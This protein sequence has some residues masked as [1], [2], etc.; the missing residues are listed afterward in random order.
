MNYKIYTTNKHYVVEDLITTNQSN[1]LRIDRETSSIEEIQIN[2]YPYQ[3][4]SFCGIFG[5]I[6]LFLRK[7]LI[8]VTSIRQLGKVLGSETFQIKE[9]K[10]L[11]LSKIN[12]ETNL[13]EESNIQTLEEK[14]IRELKRLIES[15]D[16][17]FSYDSDLTFSRERYSQ[18]RK[19]SNS[20]PNVHPLN[21]CQRFF[22]NHSLCLE[23]YQFR[24][25]WVLITIRG[26]LKSCG[27]A[28][29][30]KSF[31]LILISRRLN[32]RSGQRFTR[33]GIDFEGNCANYVET[34]Q[35]IE[36]YPNQTDN[37]RSRDSNESPFFGNLPTKESKQKKKSKSI[38]SFIQTRGSI[39][40]FWKQTIDLSYK[41]KIEI[42]NIQPNAIDVTFQKHFQQEINQYGS[43]VAISLINKTGSERILGDQYTK[44]VRRY[45]KQYQNQPEDQIKY[46]EFDFHKQCSK[47][48]WHN[49]SLLT[50]Q[51][52]KEIQHYSFCV[53]GFNQVEKEIEIG[54]QKIQKQ[55]GTFR[56]NCLDC[57][58]R[59]NVVQSLIATESL[60]KQLVYLGV[61]EVG[62][63]FYIFEG[64]NRQFKNIWADNADIISKQYSGTPAL[65]TDFTRTGE[66][67]VKGMLK[68]AKNSLNRYYINNFRDGDNQDNIDLLLG[69]VDQKSIDYFTT[70]YSKSSAIEKLL[71]FFD[72]LWLFLIFS[73]TFGRKFNAQFK[74]HSRKVLNKPKFNINFSKKNNKSK[75]SQLTQVNNLNKNPLLQGFQNEKTNENINEN[76]FLH[77]IEV[78]QKIDML[79]ET[80]D[81]F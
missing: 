50:N 45:N 35:L 64:F 79:P 62:E 54:Y 21:S 49:L 42:S 63:P 22:Y 41:P 59:T 71:W 3:G 74:S 11:P 12:T 38:T 40:V 17:Y 69:K 47:M 20:L 61:L 57:L 48:R 32:E 26:F 18:I 67:T 6:K 30:D 75:S 25:T 10:F 9:C 53:E 52:Q 55:K 46:I 66:R 13:S 28:L 51:I 19:K 31:K 34:E 56:T 70:N 65:K 43:Q 39:P 15:G 23:F 60:N 68:D 14:Q 78:E 27:C 16:F 80:E 7:Y 4:E 58:D 29:K 72:F 2:K 81:E 33:R 73:I 37:L 1:F 8:I 77:D 76:I 24:N 44:Y 36:Y 5:I